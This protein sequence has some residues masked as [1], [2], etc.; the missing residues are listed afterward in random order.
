MGDEDDA[1]AMLNIHV[2]EGCD[3]LP[4]STPTSSDAYVVVERAPASS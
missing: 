2:I 3:L 1:C 4:A